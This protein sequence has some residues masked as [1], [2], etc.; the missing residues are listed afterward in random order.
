MNTL[1]TVLPANEARTNFYQ[2]L[3][4]VGSNLR[5]FTISHRGKPGAIIM[6]IEEFEGW[7]E[8]M[9]IMSDKKLVKSI[10]RARKSTKTYSQEEVD[11]MLGW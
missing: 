6:S 2:I 3:D 4:E 8:T 1:S 7:Q 5:Q 11:K 10:E 9:E